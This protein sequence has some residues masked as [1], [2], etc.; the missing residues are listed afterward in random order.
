MQAIYMAA[1]Y[2][3]Y[4]AQQTQQ[5]GMHSFQAM[6]A[7]AMAGFPALPTPASAFSMMP[8]GVPP[9]MMPSAY[10]PAVIPGLPPGAANSLFGTGAAGVNAGPGLP[11]VAALA[12]ADLRP[13]HQFSGIPTGSSLVQ[14]FPSGVSG[15][16]DYG[17]YYQK[18]LEVQAAA[19]LAGGVLPTEADTVAAA[20]RLRGGIPPPPP[21]PAQPPPPPKDSKRNSGGEA[22]PVASCT[23]AS[24]AA[25]FGH[26]V[27]SGAD[28][29]RRLRSQNSGRD[30]GT[31]GSGG[32]NINIS[33]GGGTPGSPGLMSGPHSP[34]Q[35]HTGSFTTQQPNSRLRTGSASHFDG[36]PQPMSSSNVV[37]G[38][39]INGSLASVSNVGSTGPSYARDAL[40]GE[41]PQRR[42]SQRRGDMLAAAEAHDAVHSGGSGSNSAGGPAAGAGGRGPRSSG[43]TL[44]DEFKNNKT[45]RKYELRE[46]LGHVYEFSLDQHGSRFIQQKLEGVSPEDLD[47]A[48]SEVMPRILHLM[49]DV[50]GNYVVQKLLEHGTPEQ[51]GRVAKA[52]HGHVLQLSLQM[53]G[54][55][56]IQKA[57]EVFAEEQQV[58]LVSE[59]EGHIMRC[60]RD[61]NGNHVIQKCIECVPTHR[62]LGLLDHFLMCVVALS[63]HPFGCRIIQRIL[64]HVR[65]Q[66]RREAVMNDILGAAVQLTQ[67]QYG[68]YVIQHVLER[69][70]PEERSSIVGSLSNRVVQLSM[71]KFASNVIEKCLTY[72][73]ATDRDMLINRMLGAQ[74]LQ[75]R[76]A[77]A[78]GGVDG[79]M[80]VEVCHGWGFLIRACFAVWFHFTPAGQ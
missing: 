1:M 15:S 76:Q 46:I 34:S 78:V 9:P 37:N 62:I 79:D 16:G 69:G 29:E 17:V 49:T 36:Q 70:A 60:V 13:Q 20:T 71:H 4:Y 33:A 2:P 32:T 48:F 30:L 58:E 43:D 56:V 11:D 10:Q 24:S 31:R 80:E 41:G 53:Y 50:F 42:N 22:H 25:P 21:P 66:K 74:A 67:D 28:A 8:G 51:C 72:G 27:A 3:M 77:A 55:R 63:T 61:Q 68:N 44:L 5:T 12:A 40:R 26:T 73:S 18:M 75:M 64:E 38:G 23:A 59:L 45:G 14:S 19:A 57:L 39:G 35:T 7:A 54:C 6:Q 47:A 65:D 52:L